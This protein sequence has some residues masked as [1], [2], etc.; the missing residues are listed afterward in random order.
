MI[1]DIFSMAASAGGGAILGLF[2]NF[3]QA[4]VEKKRIEKDTAIANA[5]RDAKTLKSLG[6]NLNIDRGEPYERIF[7]LWGFTW[8]RKGTKPDK[9]IHP[10]YASHLLL[11]TT[12][13]CICTLIAYALGDIAIA[14]KSPSAD[15]SVWK[16]GPFERIEPNNTV[17][18]V[19]FASVGVYNTHFLA[20]IMSA[21]YTHIIPKRIR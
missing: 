4:G 13:F 8:I 19:T 15:P 18:V 1:D 20:F 3:I 16:F 17:S 14:T 10:P 12:T 2:T 6:A 5:T 11:I 7:K 9:P 21:V